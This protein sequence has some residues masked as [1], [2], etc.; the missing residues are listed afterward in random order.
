MMQY[1]VNNWFSRKLLAWCVIKA[2]AI[3]TT[4]KYTDKT[5]EEVTLFMVYDYLTG[6]E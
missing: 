6:K 5:P 2:W 3:A 1:I 4:E